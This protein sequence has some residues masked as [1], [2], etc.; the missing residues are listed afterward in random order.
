MD[1]K[2][3]KWTGLK[4]ANT[5]CYIFITLKLLEKIDWSWWWVLSPIWINMLVGS[6]VCTIINYVNRD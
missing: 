3:M 4:D 6:I 1:K 2:K 5:L